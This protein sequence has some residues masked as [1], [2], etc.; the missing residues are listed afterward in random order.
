MSKQLLYIGE[1]MAKEPTVPPEPE[2]PWTLDDVFR[3]RKGEKRL[4]Y[5]GKDVKRG[6]T[7]MVSFRC[8]YRIVH[9]LQVI[10]EQKLDPEIETKSDILH[11]ALHLWLTR[12]DEDHPDG[13]GGRLAYQFRM[14][15]LERKMANQDTF[16]ESVSRILEQLKEHRD[17]AGIKE[18][19]VYIGE[20][21]F[22]FTDAPP[23]FLEKL[24]E[25]QEE[26]RRL[27]KGE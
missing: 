20:A 2:S 25:V 11:D 22:D 9:R 4:R 7:E 14:R 16:L 18:L 10:V 5:T 23:L 13:A 1:P 8:D 3:Q 27:V 17:V 15:D 6:E 19:L 12:W 26:A 24:G 21:R